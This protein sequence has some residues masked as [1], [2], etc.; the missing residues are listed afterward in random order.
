LADNVKD[1]GA[2][3]MFPALADQWLAQVQ[4]EKGWRNFGIQDFH[5][6][7]SQYGVS[8]VVLQ[9]PGLPGMACPFQN[10][11]VR[12]CS[13]TS[14]PVEYASHPLPHAHGSGRDFSAGA[15]AT[16]AH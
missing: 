9:Q 6:L 5:R 7:R 1:S 10:H 8:W 12:V 16:R 15:D 13:L 11:A 14:E 2:V 4:A 3:S